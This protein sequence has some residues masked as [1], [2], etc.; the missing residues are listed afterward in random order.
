MLRAS[1]IDWTL[2][3]PR[4]ACMNALLHFALEGEV[5]MKRCF[6]YPAL[7]T[8]VALFLVQTAQ[9]NTMARS[10]APS[11]G[12]SCAASLDCPNATNRFPITDS[13]APLPT[14]DLS[15]SASNSEDIHVSQPGLAHDGNL[16]DPL[17]TGA[18]HSFDCSFFDAAVSHF[19]FGTN[20]GSSTSLGDFHCYSSPPADSLLM[21]NDPACAWNWHTGPLFPEDLAAGF[22]PK[23]LF[24]APEPSSLA[25]LG[26]GCLLVYFSLRRATK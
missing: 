18:S 26:S 9:G 1:G 10:L 25:L 15:K 13:L 16:S 14:G 8:A 3:G 23:P 7:I 4:I 6:R 19:N 24:P 5:Q 11:N 22:G 12:F 21:S 2:N 20:C 17:L